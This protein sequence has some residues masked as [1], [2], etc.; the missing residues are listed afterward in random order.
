MALVVEGAWS[1]PTGWYPPLSRTVRELSFNGELS[2]GCG[3]GKIDV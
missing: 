3:A 1:P 2:L